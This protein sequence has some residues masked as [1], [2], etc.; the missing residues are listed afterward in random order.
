MEWAAGGDGPRKWR[1]APRQGG[2]RHAWGPGLGEGVAQRRRG[3]LKGGGP[4]PWRSVAHPRGRRSLGGPAPAPPH[5]RGG[6]GAR[7]GA[8]C[9]QPARRRVISLQPRRR[10]ARPRRDHSEGVHVGGGQHH[11]GATPASQASRQRRAHRHQRSPGLRP[12][13]AGR[14]AGGQVV[15]PQLAEVEEG[16]GDL[17]ADVVAADILGVGLAAAGA[18][19]AGQR[20]VAAGEK[21]P[22]ST[23]RASLGK[24]GAQSGYP[25]LAALPAPGV[26]AHPSMPRWRAS[27]APLGQG[28][29]A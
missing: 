22:P 1:C 26:G 21:R 19:P 10:G 8:P 17:H 3:T 9:G 29:S 16:L 25:G 6:N 11:R 15:A 23:L 12:A 24:I 18:H 7:P 27:P 14:A 28:G 20:V 5:P 13:K 4:H 2:R